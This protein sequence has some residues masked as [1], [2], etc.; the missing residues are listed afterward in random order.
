MAILPAEIPTGIV[1][2]QFYFVNEDNVD[3][4]TDPNLTV[5]QGDVVFTCSAPVLRMPTK[6]ATVIPLEF[7]A[8]F[9]GSGQLVSAEDATV[10]LELP[11]TDSDLFNPTDF[12]WEVSFDLVQLENRHTVSIDS[13][14]I[15]V[16]EGAVTDLTLAMPVDAS[17]GTLTVQGPQGA[18]GDMSLVTGPSN[19][20]GTI[21]LTE[22][23]LPSTRLYTLTGNTT[24][25]LPTPAATPARSGTITL[26]LT[27]D[28]TGNRTVTWPAAVKWPDGIAQQPAVAANSVS[29]IHLLWTGAAWYGLVGGKSFA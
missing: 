5:V 23:N 6:L 7:K 25:V 2:G 14:S 17:P 22:A 29:V 15:Q 8:Q 3:A 4:D 19:A 24:F 21:T 1:T 11:A 16:P 9:N 28:A 10:G 13:F 26:V 12:T 27:Q 20:T 18:V